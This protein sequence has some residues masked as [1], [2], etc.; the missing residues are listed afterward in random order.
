LLEML[1]DAREKRLRLVA[2]CDDVLSLT[3]RSLLLV[4]TNELILAG[5]K[6][7]LTGSDG[8]T[9]GLSL[10]VVSFADVMSCLLTALV[11]TVVVVSFADVIWC[12]S[13][14]GSVLVGDDGSVL[15]VCK[16]ADRSLLTDVVTVADRVLLV[17]LNLSSV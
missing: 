11:V 3:T 14:T 5:L 9:F 6:D 17:S 12:S 7:V 15:S 2:V 8:V 13:V 4:E 16:D 10:L 1:K